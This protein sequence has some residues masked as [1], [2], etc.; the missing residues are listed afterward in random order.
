MT[1]ISINERKQRLGIRHLLTPGHRCVSSAPTTNLVGT[2]ADS[3]VALHSSDPA[4][5][6]LSIAARCHGIALSDIDRG[7]YQNPSVVRHHGMRRTIW[8]V[9]AETATMMHSAVTIKI[10]AA[11]R[12]RL[13]KVLGRPEAWLDEAISEIEALTSEM[14]P[15]PSIEIGR[16]L[17]RLAFPIVLGPNTKHSVS[18]NAHTR[19][20]VQAGF[21]AR[22]VRTRPVGSWTA[23][24]YSWVAATQWLKGFPNET[25]DP[26]TQRQ[27][28]ADLVDR[29]LQRFGPGTFT[30]IVWWTGM[31]K[32][33]V[34]AA[35]AD[36]GAVEVQL[37]TSSGWLSSHD[38]TVA[39]NDADQ[40][41]AALLP[42]LDPTSMG[43]KDRDWYLDPSIASEIVDRNG[44]IGPTIWVNGSIV[45]SWNQRIDGSI[46]T[47]N[48]LPLSRSQTALVNVEI[49]RLQALLGSAVVK[50]RFPAPNQRR[51]VG[52][53]AS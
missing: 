3:L 2:V 44:N 40:P 47:E 39:A 33:D 20:V 1:R 43:W 34:T 22:L 53:P 18:V 10:A 9:S 14:G 21:E 7:L 52:L 8:V 29:W 42:G 49:E 41:W 38:T 45:G 15:L 28:K 50:P 11:E 26:D 36:C 17:P 19:I 30:D 37:P 51:L 23:S 13:L 48:Y 46:V 12:R 35:L 6:Y 31:T 27:D 24:N 16:R 5:V 32:R 4:S 25:P